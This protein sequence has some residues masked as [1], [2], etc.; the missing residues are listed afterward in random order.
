[1]YNLTHHDLHSNLPP[2]YVNSFNLGFGVA[3]GAPSWNMEQNSHRKCRW[4]PFMSGPWWTSF[5]CDFC[6]VRTTCI[7]VQQGMCLRLTLAEHVCAEWLWCQPCCA[8]QCLPSNHS[9]LSLLL[10]LSTVENQHSTG[11]WVSFPWPRCELLP[12][13]AG[14]HVGKLTWSAKK[15]TNSLWSKKMLLMMVASSLFCSV[16]SSGKS[17]QLITSWDGT[18]TTRERKDPKV[19]SFL[20]CIVYG[21]CTICIYMY[22]RNSLGSQM[23]HNKQ[24]HMTFRLIFDEI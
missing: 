21:N 23:L 11:K 10:P 17:I 9:L 16:F 6:Y 18:S 8:S 22:S 13:L 4:I 3:L 12:S 5:S 20:L 15:A 24:K 19:S 7:H 14:L 2:R 1:M